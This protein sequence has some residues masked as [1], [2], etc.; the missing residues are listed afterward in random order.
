MNQFTGI[1]KSCDSCNAPIKPR[2]VKWT[3]DEYGTLCRESIICDVCHT[4]EQQR[5][6]EVVKACENA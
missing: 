1:C 2:K 4:L 3:Y 6:Q 5:I